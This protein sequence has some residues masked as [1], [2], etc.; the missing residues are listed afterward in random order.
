MPKP[1]L[2]NEARR[3]PSETPQAPAP[4]LFA[5]RREPPRPRAHDVG[6]TVVRSLGIG[7]AVA[8][9]AFAA[10]MISDVDR[11]PEFAGL[12]HL[13]IYSRPTILAARRAQTQVADS[14][15]KV[16]YTPVGSIGDA[17]NEP[18]LSGYALLEMRGGSALIQTPNAIIRIS[19][20]DVVAGL[21]RITSFERRG[22]KWVVV[23]PSGLIVGH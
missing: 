14:R 6:E 20:G 13:A 12:E 1:T 3:A 11:K 22:E 2:R 23:T 5:E 21:G 15:S 9:T 8:S 7:M 10:Y 4:A 17:K 19:P 18:T 16:D